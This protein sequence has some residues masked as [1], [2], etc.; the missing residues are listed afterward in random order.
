MQSA[1][2]SLKCLYTTTE[3]PKI[4][5][6][7]NLATAWSG[8]DRRCLD[9]ELTPSFRCQ[10][11][12]GWNMGPRAAGRAP[13]F[14]PSWLP[15][16]GTGGAGLPPT[17]TRGEDPP[18]LG[19]GASDNRKPGGTHT[20]RVPGPLMQP[21]LSLTRPPHPHNVPLMPGSH[22]T[23]HSNPSLLPREKHM[24]SGPFLHPHH[25]QAPAGHLP[26]ELSTV[27]SRD[28]ASHTELQS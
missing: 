14:S 23:P 9:L 25:F 11:Q 7:Q 16:G 17:Q 12:C 20:P 18:P 13:T 2:N 22:C 6:G 19:R 8:Q 10:V 26:P 15:K 3:P 4:G 1:I 28:S 24:K 27:P 5:Q 21:S